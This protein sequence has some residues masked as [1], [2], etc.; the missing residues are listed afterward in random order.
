M[1]AGYGIAIPVGAIALLIV[2]M[3][4]RRGFK[5]GFF[6]GA[7]AACADLI[8]A[9]LAALAGSQLAVLLQPVAQRI[10]QLSGLV[11]ILLGA[12]GLVRI[13]RQSRP[14]GSTGAE[15]APGS[16]VAILL[17][18]LGLTLLNPLTVAYFA[19]LILGGGALGI[20]T[21]LDRVG[22]VL[23]AGIA[24][25]SWQTLLA[26]VGAWGNRRLSAR[27]QLLASVL[28]NMVVVGFGVLILS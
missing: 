23:G 14:A 21:N 26:G 7:G 2:E 24:S 20:E 17:K 9:G 15:P 10:Q 6:A 22:F 3:G 16:S 1:L 25:L 12:N 11:L 4:L 18:F 27:A 8:Y 28:G 19:A 5:S 13:W